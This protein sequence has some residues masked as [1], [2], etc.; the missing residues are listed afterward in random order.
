MNTIK[1]IGLWCSMF[2]NKRYRVG[3]TYYEPTGNY[4]AAGD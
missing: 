4:K 2:S 3:L 1:A